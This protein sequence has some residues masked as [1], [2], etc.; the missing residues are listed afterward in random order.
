MNEITSKWMN[1]KQLQQNKIKQKK[2]LKEEKNEM[3]NKPINQYNIFFKKYQ[4][5]F[6]LLLIIA[7]FH[8]E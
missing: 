1:E 4:V 6:G 7:C 8:N 3:N 5:K 2:K